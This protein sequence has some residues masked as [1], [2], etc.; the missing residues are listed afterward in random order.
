MVSPTEER[1]QPLGDPFRSRGKESARPTL[2]QY[3]RPLLAVFD[4]HFYLTL[5]QPCEVGLLTAISQSRKERPGGER[6]LVRRHVLKGESVGRVPG[7]SACK[8]NN[9][10]RTTGRLA[11]CSLQTCCPW[12]VRSPRISLW[13]TFPQSPRKLWRRPMIPSVPPRCRCVGALLRIR[14][15]EAEGRVVQLLPHPLQ[16]EGLSSACG[17]GGAAR[18]GLLL[19]TLCGE[20]TRGSEPGSAGWGKQR[21][22]RK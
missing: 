4:S 15:V 17:V 6:C 16:G 20:Q 1:T 2:S 7:L 14:P 12:E 22:S 11:R 10:P 3:S 9:S 18:L 8:A 21:G 19:V 13:G 5:I